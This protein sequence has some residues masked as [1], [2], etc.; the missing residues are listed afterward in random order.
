MSFFFVENRKPDK[1]LKGLSEGFLRRHSCNVCPL[2]NIKN[3]SPKMEPSGSKTPT[4]MIVGEAPGEQEDINAKHF[5]GKSGRLLRGHLPEEWRERIRWSNAVNCRPPDNRTPEAIELS[6]CKPRLDKDIT[7]TKPK[8]ILGFGMVPLAQIVSPDSKYRKISLWRGRRLPVK[9]GDHVCWYY[10]M[11]H[12]SYILRAPHYKESAKNGYGTEDGFAFAFDIQRALW[13]IDN[14]LPEPVIHSVEDAESDIE[15]VEDINRV[16]E[17]LEEAGNELTAGVDLETNGLRPYIK[18]AK[19]LTMGV[20][21]RKGT[22]AFP[23]DHS[24]ATWTKLERKQ[25]DVLIKRFLY[26]S[27][28][29]KLVHNLAFELEWFGFF[30]GTGCFY[31]SFWECTLSQAYI[32]DARRGG[33]SLDFLCFVNFGINL[34]AISGLDRANLDKA[35]LQQV[36]KYQGIDAKYHRLLF[37]AQR[38]RIKEDDLEEVYEHQMRRIPA[39]VLTQMQGVPVDQSVVADLRKKWEAR[40]KTAEKEIM[41]DESILRFEK[42]KKRKF[43]PSSPPDVNYLMKEILGLEL[44]S[45]EKG[46]L[47][48]VDHPIAGKIVAF[49]EAWKVISTYIVPCDAKSEESNIFPDGLLHPIF[50]TTTVVSWRTSSTDPNAQNYPKRDEERKEV[51]AQIR[52]KDRNM[53]VVSIDYAGIQARNVA[54]ESKD[55]KLVDVY[56]HE[57]DIHTDWMDRILKRYPK[58]IKKSD[59]NNKEKMKGYRYLAKNRF[60]F[61]SFFGAQSFT[62][63]EGLG[64]PKDISEELREEFFDEFRDIKKWHEDLDN[65][66]YQHGYVTGHSGFKCRAPIAANQRINL[67]IQGDESII[68]LDAL[69]RLSE[70]EDPR[71]QPMLEVHDDL[72]FLWPKNEVEKRL[73]V[74][75]QT[76]INVP[77]EWTKIVPIEVEASWGED[78]I[79]MTE[80]GK[81]AN[82]K[83]NNIIQMPK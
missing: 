68:V 63:S 51:R 26:E 11:F 32:L 46:E 16:A 21:S 53:R 72:T 25:L 73:E 82:N 43:L 35:P 49:R 48:H 75:V 30:Y 39:L 23:V 57:Y 47:A 56:W 42:K 34:K 3:H 12:P 64:I 37:L 70:M 5:V 17:L 50:S 27:K 55:K 2:N 76:L 44:E 65:F 66:Y 60:V 59:L 78:W 69:C 14:N 10:P 29:K 13:E 62:L 38:P 8:A 52:H 19:I 28:C 1:N 61:P 22:F 80:I 45:S 71:Y 77:F 36:L 83:W 41:E 31:A 4:I 7:A 24:Q 20:S 79:N 74:V 54:M 81:Y 9:V 67:P 40:A 15:L 58:W 6:C 18:G 33:L